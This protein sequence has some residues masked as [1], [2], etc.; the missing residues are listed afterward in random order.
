LRI[1]SSAI[2]SSFCRD[3]CTDVLRESHTIV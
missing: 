3:G 2:C 1:N